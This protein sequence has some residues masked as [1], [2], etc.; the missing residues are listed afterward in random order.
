MSSKLWRRGSK[1]P[2]SEQAQP[3]AAVGCS[4][5]W[6][7]KCKRE[8]RKAIKSLKALIASL[9]SC[10]LIALIEGEEVGIQVVS[11]VGHRRA[12]LE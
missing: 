6:G 5:K 3:R 11:Q 10:G 1:G 9:E 8:D 2:V 12:V 4:K 7:K